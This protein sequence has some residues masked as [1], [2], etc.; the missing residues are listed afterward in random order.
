MRKRSFELRQQHPGLIQV[1]LVG[2]WIGNIV[3]LWGKWRSSVRGKSLSLEQFDYPP[4]AVEH[5]IGA[6]TRRYVEM[7]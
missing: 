4:D 7:L 6:Y 2:E 3:Y 5:L 1:Y